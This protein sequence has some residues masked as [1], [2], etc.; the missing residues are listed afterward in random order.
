MGPQS[1][2]L[3]RPVSLCLIRGAALGLKMRDTFKASLLKFFTFCPETV[4]LFLGQQ[5]D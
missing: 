1:N 4:L 5:N 2:A 3:I